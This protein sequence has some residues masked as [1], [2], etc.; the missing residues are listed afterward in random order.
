MEIA[1]RIKEIKKEKN[2]LILAHYYQSEEVQEVSDFIGDSLQLAQ[3]AQK[4]ESDIIVLCGVYF[5]AE[6]AKILNENKKVLIPDKYAGC[7]L[8]D[9]FSLSTLLKLKKLYSDHV[10][11]SYINSSIDVKAESDIICTSSNAI[12]IIESIPKDKG[13]IFTP[14][15]NLGNYLMNIT[16]RKMILADSHCYVHV[17]FSVDMLLDVKERN[18]D[19]KIVAHPECEM[20]IITLADFVGSTSQILNF[21]SKDSSKKYIV[22]T[23]PGILYKMK[24]Q[25]P[26]KEFIFLPPKDLSLGTENYCRT[27]KLITLENLLEALLYEKFEVI[28]EKELLEKAK[29][30]IIKMME[31]SK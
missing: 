11:V 31:L 15:K 26:D 19:A 8:A 12:K 18:L 25:N 21:V 28:I 1:E 5:M 3:A 23:E 13:I 7:F 30:P 10:V 2:A 9:N 6:T 22:L 4:A 14:D 20:P 16:G 17:Q 27:M 24:K 29:K